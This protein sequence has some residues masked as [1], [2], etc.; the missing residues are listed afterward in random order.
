MG[1]KGRQVGSPQR[2]GGPGCH[3]FWCRLA[4]GFQRGLWA[5]GQMGMFMGIEGRIYEI[6]S[7]L[8]HFMQYVIYVYIYVVYIYIYTHL[9]Y[10][11]NLIYIYIFIYIYISI[12]IY[13]SNYIWYMAYMV[14]F[15]GWTHLQGRRRRRRGRRGPWRCR[16]RRGHGRGR[17]RGR[18]WRRRGGDFRDLIFG[19]SQKSP[20]NPRFCIFGCVFGDFCGVWGH[21]RFRF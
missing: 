20:K 17:R 13:L 11:S 5:T 15:M 8:W 6:W 16:R 7:T 19:I 18:R 10:T 1:A 12:Y 14:I 21:F 3:R 4:A 2:W 9:I